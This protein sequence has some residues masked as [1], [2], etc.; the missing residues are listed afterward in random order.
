MLHIT[1][2]VLGV[3]TDSKSAMRPNSLNFSSEILQSAEKM[4][5]NTCLKWG[6]IPH[7]GHSGSGYKFSGKIHYGFHFEFKLVQSKSCNNKKI[8]QKQTL[9]FEIGKFKNVS[10]IHRGQ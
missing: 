1:L 2:P 10:S 4:K 9:M 6:S 5:E 7:L 3:F 8:S